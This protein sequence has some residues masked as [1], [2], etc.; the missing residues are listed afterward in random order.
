MRTQKCI[1]ELWRIEKSELKVQNPWEEI[2]ILVAYAF[3]STPHNSCGFNKL[4][5]CS[6][7]ICSY[8]YSCVATGH[9]N[10]LRKTKDIN[11]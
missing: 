7:K 5:R 6:N 3:R 4:N 2:L 10:W 8:Q 9:K 1:M 11:H